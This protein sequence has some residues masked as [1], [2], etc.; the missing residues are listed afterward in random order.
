MV[1]ISGIELKDQHI[2][3][4]ALTGLYGIGV[5]N[6]RRI[7]TDAKIDI[8]K[9]VKDLTEDEV[10]R[11]QKVLEKG[12]T[13]EGDLRRAIHDNIQRLKT[14]GSYRGSRHTHGL[15]SRGQRTRSN[16]RTKRGSRKTVGAMKK[17]DRVK[18]DQP[19]TQ[20]K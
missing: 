18:M 5:N 14:I 2:V 15:P 13:V 6:S 1:R 12:Y 10:K 20:T 3:Q 17:E 16:A 19:A 4:Y 9:R 11:I 7:L 8:T